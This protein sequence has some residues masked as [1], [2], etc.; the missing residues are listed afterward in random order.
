LTAEARAALELPPPRSVVAPLSRRWEASALADLATFVGRREL[1]RGEQ[2]DA[3]RPSRAVLDAVAALVDQLRPREAEFETND[4]S[5]LLKEQ[6]D[7]AERLVDLLR[8]RGDD[9]A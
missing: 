2:G 7:L 8:Q 9:A 4:F 6:G 5:D 1:A 3:R